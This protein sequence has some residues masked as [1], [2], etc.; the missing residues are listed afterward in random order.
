LLRQG[1]STAEL[2]ERLGVSLVRWAEISAGCIVRVVA[3][4][5]EE[6]DGWKL[7]R[8]GGGA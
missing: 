5:L 4:G 7:L 6:V 3:L 8:G 1:C 2:P